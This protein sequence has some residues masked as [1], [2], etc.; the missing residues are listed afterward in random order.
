MVS[1][2]LGGLM[3]A[4]AGMAST[5][6]PSFPVAGVVNAASG[7][8]A[9]APY[10]I[11]S[12]YGSNLYLN[13]TAAASGLYNVPT[14]LG[15]V[16]VLIGSSFA[17]ILFLSANQ[18]NFLLPNSLLPGSY[19][20]RVVRDGLS[21]TQV[22][23]VVQEA[24]P[25]L[26]AAAGV[27]QAFHAD[28]TAVDARAPALGDEIVVFYGTGFGRAQP[29]PGALEIVQSAASIVHAG[30]F[31]VILDGAAID[32]SLVQY[33]GVAPFNAGLYQVNVRMPSDLGTGNPLLQVSVAGY[34]SPD[35]VRLITGVQPESQARAAK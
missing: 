5:P 25:A 23:F 21:S 6:G 34:V 22:P 14:Q 20:I 29:D 32:P 2:L 26:F 16:T 33:V 10:T 19:T 1:R 28:G 18:I 12:I 15:G 11:C 24:A 27:V 35:N 3:L 13:G 31:Q 17:G 9:L 30:D 4:A 7:Q 8:T